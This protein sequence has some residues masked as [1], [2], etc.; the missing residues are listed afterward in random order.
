MEARTGMGL[1][2]CECGRRQSLYPD[3]QRLDLLHGCEHGQN[4]LGTQHRERLLSRHFFCVDLKTG[5]DVWKF[6]LPE[7]T[8]ATCRHRSAMVRSISASF[9]K[10]T[11]VRHSSQAP[12]CALMLGPA[13]RSG[14][15]RVTAS[16]DFKLGGAC[17]YI[18]NDLGN[19]HDKH[20]R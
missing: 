15:S 19:R 20:D 7:G 11:Y 16:V 9:P 13:K 10:G 17:S 8:N 6:P 4:H 1:G 12:P 14:R 5:E 18:V 2:V 3:R